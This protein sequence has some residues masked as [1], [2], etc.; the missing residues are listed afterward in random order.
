ME[1]VSPLD[2]V[3]DVCLDRAK[4]IKN[5]VVVNVELTAEEWK[6]RYEKEK[7]KNA[8]LKAQLQKKELELQ[9]W[10]AG[11]FNVLSY[12]KQQCCPEFVRVIETTF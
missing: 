4:T 6:N 3:L 7:E 11:M 1:N 2:P 12:N 9:R 10:R 8:K 5:T